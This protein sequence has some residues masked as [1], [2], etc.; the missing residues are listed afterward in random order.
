MI[1]D[2]LKE[3]IKKLYLS[4]DKANTC[5]EKGFIWSFLTLASNLFM[6][7]EINKMY[8]DI[9]LRCLKEEKAL[10][11]DQKNHEKEINKFMKENKR[12]FRNNLPRALKME[13]IEPYKLPSKDYHYLIKI[14]ESFL[15][16]QSIKFY[17]F[18]K[19]MVLEE[20][21]IMGDS[22]QVCFSSINT[23]KTF[24]FLEKFDN[25]Y[26]VMALIHELAHAYY[27]EINNEILNDRVILENEIK[28][29]IPSKMVEL[30]FIRYLGVIN[31]FKSYQTLKKEYDYLIYNHDQYRN[32]FD[33]IKYVI[34]SYL[35]YEQEN[36]CQIEDYFQHVYQS[37][38]HDLIIEVQAKTQKE[39][40]GK[41]LRK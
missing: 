18:Y 20:R 14:L 24:I 39:N 27:Y 28:D 15:K 5:Y 10:L 33:M 35:A 31:L 30:K 11:I 4:F 13:K 38:F 16:S 7:D 25:L 36:Y 37:D 29:E 2:K 8:E 32:D 12:F 3:E 23:S 17:D 41:V 1:G 19:K 26:D 34:G 21:I 40:K 6:D 9:S 22:N